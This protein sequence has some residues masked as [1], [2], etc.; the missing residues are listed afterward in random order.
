MLKINDTNIISV[1]LVTV[2]SRLYAY[3]LANNMLDS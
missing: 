2:L 1:I 3:N